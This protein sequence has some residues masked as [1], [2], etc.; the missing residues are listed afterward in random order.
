MKRIGEAKVDHP[1]T[2]ENLPP[3]FIGGSVFNYQYCSNPLALPVKDVV[4]K[5][6]DMGLNAIDTSPYY[7]PSEEL[8]GNALKEIKFN[9]DQYYICTKAGRIQLN[10]FDYSR[11]NVRK[12]V[13][14]SLDRLH[15]SYLDLV[16]MHDIEFVEEEMI[17]EA[18]RE[19]KLLKQQG[20][21]R[22]F[23]IS[24]YPVKFLHKIA[25][26][27]A[28]N[29]DV[30]PLDAILSYSNGC[31]QNTILFDF[32]ESFIKQCK[33]KKV[34]N[35]SILSMSLLRAQET[36]SF[37]PADIKL[38]QKVKEIAS[39]LHTK[40]NVDLA[41]LAT[42]FA[43]KRWLFDTIPQENPENLTWNSKTSIVLGVS[44]VNELEVGVSAYNQVKFNENNI[45]TH[46]DELFH[47]VETELENHLNEVW[48]S[49]IH[50]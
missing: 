18:L 16:Y 23:G 19:L 10:E 27:C 1:Y 20:K 50:T 17:Y 48:P 29:N 34:L 12:S 11:D 9:R 41:D 7:G 47:L 6:F 5:A 2:I 4:E 35:G 44:N 42:R 39:I 15:T 28:N 45:N 13:E 46:D 43:I 24:G 31:I 14:R 37:H 26:E 49:G 33:I 25:Y 40:Y 36:H 8:L 21:I 32:Y 22:N 3:I 38:K 30:G